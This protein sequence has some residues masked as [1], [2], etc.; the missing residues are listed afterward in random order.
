MA[1]RLEGDG[2]PVIN[3]LG[4]GGLH[5]HLAIHPLSLRPTRVNK[6]HEFKTTEVSVVFPPPAS[7][8]MDLHFHLSAFT[9]VVVSDFPRQM[10]GSGDLV[11]VAIVR[12]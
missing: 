1:E 12:L 11:D 5:K 9:T 7:I 6:P 3:L 10:G 2:T 8:C 4:S